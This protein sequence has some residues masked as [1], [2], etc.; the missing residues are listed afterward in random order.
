VDTVAVVM[1]GAGVFLLYE[2]VHNP[3]PG[4][5]YTPTPL[6]TATSLI[7]KSS[8]SSGVPAGVVVT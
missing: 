5:P 2:A 8:T 4:Q 6:K 3:N 1:I 7:P